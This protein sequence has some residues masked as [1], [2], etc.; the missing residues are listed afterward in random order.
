MK[1]TSNKL[2][3]L[4]LCPRWIRT[5]QSLEIP[6]LKQLATKLMTMT[7]GEVTEYVG[8]SMD[9]NKTMYQ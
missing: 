1:N 7:V 8:K 4:K 6:Q 9:L 5:K 3:K 2:N